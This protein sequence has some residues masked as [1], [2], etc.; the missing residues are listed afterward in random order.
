MAII[1]SIIIISAIGNCCFV[2]NM[3]AYCQFPMAYSIKEKSGGSGQQL[4][5]EVA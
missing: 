5:Y 3:I 2:V 4:M 1:F